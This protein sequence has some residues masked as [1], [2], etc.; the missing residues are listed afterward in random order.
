MALGGAA[1]GLGRA[2][3]VRVD[4]GVWSTL[5]VNLAGA[6][7]LGFLVMYARS[8]WRPAVLAGVSVG[9]LGA[10][11]TFST[12]A[13]ELTDMAAA[14]DWPGMAAYG[15]VSLVGGLV[16]ATAGLRLGRSRA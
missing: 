13:G 7:L 5:G 14:G 9:L 11:T 16:V 4:D 2:A 6:F 10:L 3:L 1:G 15:G 8:R 12:L